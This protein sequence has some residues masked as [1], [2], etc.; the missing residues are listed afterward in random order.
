MM[1]DNN[2]TCLKQI[3]GNRSAFTMGAIKD[4]SDEQ[5]FS[6]LIGLGVMIC[7]FGYVS[8]YFSTTLSSCCSLTQ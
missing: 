1:K 8:L 3:Q 2:G 6:S 7:I 5:T 4:C